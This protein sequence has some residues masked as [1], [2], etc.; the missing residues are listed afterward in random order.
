[1]TACPG[2]ALS[3]HPVLGVP[4]GS[5]DARGE[6]CPRPDRRHRARARGALT[7]FPVECSDMNVTRPSSRLALVG[8]AALS[9]VLLL[10][11]PPTPM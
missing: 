7:S 9:S 3:A 5:G 6:V 2:P 1:M 8:G 10:S 4:G 11:P